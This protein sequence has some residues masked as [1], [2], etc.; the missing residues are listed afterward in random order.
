M[1]DFEEFVAVVLLDFV[2]FKGLIDACFLGL[3][4]VELLLKDLPRLALI[5]VLKHLELK[6]FVQF[7]VDGFRPLV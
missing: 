4:F 1:G 7:S 2:K 5:L 6:I 3:E